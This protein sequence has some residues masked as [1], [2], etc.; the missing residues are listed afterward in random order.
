MHRTDTRIGT[1][2]TSGPAVGVA[3]CRY[4][5][6]THSNVS[7]CQSKRD[8][9]TSTRDL[10]R[11]G[12]LICC[13]TSS[14]SLKIRYVAQIG[15][16]VDHRRPVHR[17][18]GAHAVLDQSCH[19]IVAWLA[20]MVLVRCHADHVPQIQFGLV[21][22]HGVAQPHPHGVRDRD[23]DDGYEMCVPL[24]DGHH[25]AL[26]AALGWPG[27]VGAPRPRTLACWR[28]PEEKKAARETWSHS[29]PRDVSAIATRT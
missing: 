21:A 22:R 3:E 2:S 12:Y 26:S 24:Y 5:L 9:T 14:L 20:R 11:P 18:R 10:M 7:D 13:S 28:V 15:R 8:G 4:P 25:Q 29:T 1:V 19:E 23:G 17:Q 16:A 27:D 6:R